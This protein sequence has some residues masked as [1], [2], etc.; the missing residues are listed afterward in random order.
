M[1]N[2]YYN[3]RIYRAISGFFKKAFTPIPDKAPPVVNEQ[4]S[5]S[6]EWTQRDTLVGVLRDAAQLDIA[7]EHKFYHIPDKYISD[8]DFPIKYVAIYQSKKLFRNDAGIYRYGE[9]ES[10]KWVKRNTIHEIPKDS[11]EHYYRFNIKE[12]KRLEMPIEAKEHGFIRFF[13][14]FDMMLHS[15]EI[16]QLMLKNKELHEMYCKIKNAIEMVQDNPGIEPP[17]LHFG[18]LNILVELDDLVL[19]RHTKPINCFSVYDFMDLPTTVMTQIYK[20][21]KI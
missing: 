16:P 13:T 6:Q 15:T 17:I 12:W 11:T 18:N 2:S 19:F 14:N 8:S 4:S 3:R 5:S 7:L 9:V 21:T 20:Y 1:R 10:V